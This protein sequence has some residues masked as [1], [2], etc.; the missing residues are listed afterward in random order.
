MAQ[1]DFDFDYALATLDA[2]AGRWHI[3]E[4]GD[5]MEPSAPTTMSSLFM[6]V[7]LANSQSE[8]GN[9]AHG[10][11]M[12][13]QGNQSQINDAISEFTSTWT[14]EQIETWMEKHS[15]KIWLLDDFMIKEKDLPGMDVESIIFTPST[16]RTFN[17]GDGLK[18]FMIA[19]NLNVNS[20]QIFYQ[21]LSQCF[22][23]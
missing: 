12:V 18:V 10:F 17:S 7:K 14:N 5:Y 1:K 21:V 9:I 11:I 15:D 8:D 13:C 6:Q 4:L 2:T 16:M 22:W 20:A 19:R 3:T 23:A